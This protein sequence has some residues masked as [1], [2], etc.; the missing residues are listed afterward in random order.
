MKKVFLFLP[1][2]FC[3]CTQQ[4]AMKTGDTSFD[5]QKIGQ[6]SEQIKN[7]KCANIQKYKIFQVT[8][9]GALAWACETQYRV[10]TCL[11]MVVY[12]PKA[13]GSDYYDD[14][15]IEPASGQCIAYEGVFKYPTANGLYKTVPKLKF[16]TEQ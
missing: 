1:L 2:I 5:A 13:T 10:E 4:E 15:V 9:G 6:S 8:N 11:G 16:I 3:A 7:K 14:M 12:V